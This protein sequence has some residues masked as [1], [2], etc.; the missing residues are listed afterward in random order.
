[1]KDCRI[2]IG[3][4]SALPDFARGMHGN[5]ADQ[6]RIVG[7][8]RGEETITTPMAA[9]SAIA[10]I[11]ARVAVP[12]PTGELMPE[13]A[14]LRNCTACHQID[15]KIIGPSFQQIAAKYKGDSDA[16]SRLAEKVKK[17]GGGVWGPIPMPPNAIRDEDIRALVKWV[18]SGAPGK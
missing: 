15:K 9:G 10:P 7:P 18:L 17:G 3:L 14:R 16:E 11:A 6:Q 12:L 5:L 1:M 13:L 4:A 2:E 8:A